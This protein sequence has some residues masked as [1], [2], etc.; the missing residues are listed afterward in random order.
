MT[1][2]D[3]DI[4]EMLFS[5]EMARLWLENHWKDKGPKYDLPYSERRKLAE[6]HL[7]YALGIADRALKT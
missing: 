2:T 4:S 6:W 5:C 7:D 1:L 3:L